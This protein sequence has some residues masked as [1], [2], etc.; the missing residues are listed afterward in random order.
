MCLTFFFV[1]FFSRIQPFAS[2]FRALSWN[3]GLMFFSDS[4][5][6]TCKVSWSDCS[7]FCHHVTERGILMSHVNFH[8]VMLSL[9][10]RS[11]Y[12]LQSLFNSSFVGDTESLWKIEKLRSEMMKQ[13][14]LRTGFSCA[15]V[16]CYVYL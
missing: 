6:I 14:S 5:Y 4:W 16:I 8:E 15:K 10:L 7:S 13:H 2:R 12:C 11:I 1:F 3:F 9:M